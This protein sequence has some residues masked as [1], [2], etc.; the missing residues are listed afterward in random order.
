M[1]N[2]FF[3]D[4]GTVAPIEAIS[5]TK[6]PEEKPK[7]IPTKIRSKPKEETSLQKVET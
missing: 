1:T 3:N 6:I 7:M 5:I 2:Y 4:F